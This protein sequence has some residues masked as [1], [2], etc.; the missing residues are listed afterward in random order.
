MDIIAQRKPGIWIPYII[1]TAVGIW[2]LIFGKRQYDW[3]IAILLLILSIIILFLYFKTP[4]EIIKSDSNGNLYLNDGTVI[5]P[6]DIMEV[7]SRRAS[8]KGW[9]Y[10]W[11]SVTIVT[12]SKTYSFRY[13]ADCEDV[14]NK[15]KDLKYIHRVMDSDLTF[16]DVLNI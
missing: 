8:S 9:K 2:L 6:A 10:K 3:L 1:L 14:A 4:K 15:I 11:G 7:F 5:K 13:V 16:E 12:N